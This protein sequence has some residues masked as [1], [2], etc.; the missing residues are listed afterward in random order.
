[1]R[2]VLIT[3][4]GLFFN[5]I[6]GGQTAADG[7]ETLKRLAELYN[8][9]DYKALYMMLSPEF[10]GQ[11]SEADITGFYKSNLR[12]MGNIS[13][14]QAKG[15]RNGA[16]MYRV[17]F[18]NGMLDLSIYLNRS[19]EIAGM[20][21]LPAAKD[22][23]QKRE[24]SLIHTNNP[25]HTET[26]NLVDKA[27]MEHLQA[28]ASGGLSIAVIDGDKTEFFFYG[29]GDKTGNAHEPNANTLYEIG[30]ITK[31]FTGIVLAHAINE[32]KL[33][34][35][36]DVRK[37]LPGNYPNLE[38]KGEPIRIKHLA[39]HTSRLPSLPENL[40]SQAGYDEQDP[41]KSYSKEMIIDYLHTVKPDTMPGKVSEYS[42]LGV[43]LL[44]QVLQ[45]VY[46]QPLEVL[47]K[48][49]VI[50]PAKM[51][52]TTFTVAGN[53]VDKLA[54]PFNE[55]GNV[56]KSWTLGA[57]EAAGGLKS[58]LTDMVAYVRANM[59]EINA[60]YKLSH[61]KTF[62]DSQM[63]VGF[64]WMLQTTKEGQHLVWHNG[65]TSGFTSFCGYLAEKK[66]GIVVL[67]NS[68]TN[69]DGVAI[70]ILKGLKNR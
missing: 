31:T 67:H 32:G 36:D 35:D 70:N 17:Q 23:T 59:D 6:A 41:Y 25:K 42:N 47:V 16:M 14:W 33:K 26:Q 55:D 68:G 21:W 2:K 24:G 45:R 56:V 66:L 1:M 48:Q 60:D 50:A 19:K 7:E 46:Q 29:G 69:V 13:S 57:F 58:D 20:Q 53:A 9:E 52:N 12:P 11:A 22:K 30:S 49:Y 43:A 65:G 51:T 28:L 27:A 15:G 62:E 40:T 8:K 38:Y 54:T 18:A 4:I 5:L 37:Y 34:A 10:R 44:G 61:Q 39:N 63:G 3:I 64:N